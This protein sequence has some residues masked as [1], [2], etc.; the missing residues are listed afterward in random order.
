MWIRVGPNGLQA[1]QAGEGTL[2]VNRLMRSMHHHDHGDTPLI[3]G[4]MA[5]KAM[6]ARGLLELIPDPPLAIQNQVLC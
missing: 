4:P 6:A 2:L 5:S 3:L 1:L